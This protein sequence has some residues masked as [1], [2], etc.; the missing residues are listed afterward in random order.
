MELANR[1]VVV[2][3]GASG[4]GRATAKLLAREGAIVIVGDVDTAGGQALVAAAGGS[5]FLA[6]LPVDLAENAE[7]VE[8]F[9]A[10]AL[11]RAG[12]R[13]D[14]LVNGA[15]GTASCHSW[16]TRRSCGTS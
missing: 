7:S 3:G 2:T 14:G 1:S 16:R 12:G 4:I 8:A 15:G 11:Q 13:I 10:A 5:A 9:G 6:F